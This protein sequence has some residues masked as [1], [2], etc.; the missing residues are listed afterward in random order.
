[1]KFFSLILILLASPVFGEIITTDR[2][3]PLEN[4]LVTL[5]EDDLVLFDFHDTLLGERDA[6][7][8]VYG[9]K[10][11]AH[12]IKEA[13]PHLSNEKVRDLLSVALLQR[14]LHV[15]EPKSIKIIDF[16]KQQNIKTMALTAVR[17]GSLGRIHQTEVWRKNELRDH[18][19]DFREAFPDKQYLKFAE[20]WMKQHPPVFIEGVLC[21]GIVPKGEA[22]TM[23]FKK[24]DYWPKRVIFIDNDLEHH[25]SMQEWMKKQH[26]DYL[27]YYYLAAYTQ[28]KEYDEE[29]AKFQ[30]RYLIDYEKWLSDEEARQLIERGSRGAI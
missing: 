25:Q 19:F 14:K 23:F 30:I 29:R 8:S 4:I 17:T 21:S 12:W 11:L 6:I 13:A 16:L 22:L 9:K 15:I 20:F 7:F 5:T 24:I 28:S 2:L 27:G 1:M 3:D 10:R 26:I 18:G